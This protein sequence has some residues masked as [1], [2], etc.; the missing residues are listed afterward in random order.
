ML[1]R[2]TTGEETER[3]PCVTG[4]TSDEKHDRGGN[5]CDADVELTSLLDFSYRQK[6][7]SRFRALEDGEPERKRNHLDDVPMHR[8][9]MHHLP[10][11]WMAFIADG[12]RKDF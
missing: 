11:L 3:T 9:E 12:G 5:H 6:K 2:H 4:T 8:K 10:L 1:S 7:A